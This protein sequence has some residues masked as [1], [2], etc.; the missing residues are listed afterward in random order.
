MGTDRPHVEIAAATLAGGDKNQD[1]YAHGDGWAFVLDGASSFA[2][3]QPEHDGGWYAERLKEALAQELTEKSLDSTFNIVARA[4]E[5]AS[6]PHNDLE[7]CP[8]STIALARWWDDAVEVYVLGDSTAV[9]IGAE[10]VDVLSD[11]RLSGI[12]GNVRDQYRTR[13]KE[14]HG[15]DDRHR[16]LLQQ[17]QAR[18]VGARNRP[19]GYWI[20]GAEVEA[21]HHGLV[22]ARPCDSVRC[23]V[24]VTDG[25]AAGI[26]YEVVQSWEAFA[27][28]EPTEV[29][30]RVHR[31][32]GTDRQGISWPRSKVHDDK[33]A[34]VIGFHQSADPQVP[35]SG[36]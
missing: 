35:R 16:E 22:A 28:A 36:S 9:L 23:V 11:S 19:D 26:W 29:L 20:A 13:L 10:G 30:Q 33:T 34:I 21:A 18:Q 31:A 2:Q 5:E 24:L 17:L 32:E 12:A 1:R 27:A 8:T 4:I 14:G 25:A 6:A 15:F 3:T 7:T